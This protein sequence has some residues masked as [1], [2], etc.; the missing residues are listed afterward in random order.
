MKSSKRKKT[1][2]R[3]CSKLLSGGVYT[4]IFMPLCQDVKWAHTKLKCSVMWK[5]LPRDPLKGHTHMAY[6][7]DQI[8]VSM[9]TLFSSGISYKHLQSPQTRDCVCVCARIALID[10]WSKWSLT[11]S[12]DQHGILLSVR[13]HDPTKPNQTNSQTEHV[14]Q[15]EN[16]LVL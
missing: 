2:M 5:P 1:W 11:H 12:R 7:Y 10:P 6:F 9:C 3:R 4:P 13:C 15:R 8:T 16:L 14:V